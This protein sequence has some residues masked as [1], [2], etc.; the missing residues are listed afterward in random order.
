MNLLSMR[1]STR[2]QSMIGLMLLGLLVLCF[3]SL[4]QLRD[5]L[6]EDRKE[7][8]KNLVEVGAGVL[9]HFHQ[10]AQDGKL[11]ADA[12]KAAARESLRGLRYGNKDYYFIFDTH[13]VYVLLPTKPEFEGQ[14][15]REM[16]DAKGI[17]LIQELV[18]VAQ[19]GGGF[20]DY[21]FPRAGKQEAE[22][23]ISYAA[24]FAPWDWVI[25][26]GI[27]V[28]D[29][30]Q[31]FRREAMVLGGI[32]LV[33]IGLL[34]LIGW[35]IG[36]GILR[37][38]GG[39]PAAAA[40]IMQRVAAGDLTDDKAHPPADSLLGALAGMVATLRRLVT[41]INANASQ[42]VGNAEQIKRAAE[43]IAGAAEQQ[44]DATQSMAAAIE[45]LTVSSSH[46]S[47]SARDT[48]NDSRCAMSL[49]GEGSRRVTEATAAIE[50]VANTV[51]G[52]SVRIHALR[53]RANQ[54]STIA[55]VIKEIAGQTNLLALNAAIEAARAGEQG[56][57]FAV[58]ADEVRKLAE[59]TSVATTEI[60]QMIDDIQRD[61]GASVDAMND[62]L[63]KVEEGVRLAG[64]ASE[65][66]QGIEVGATRTLTR[67]AEVASATLEQS[68]AS[69]SI[70]QRVEQIS[71]MVDETTATIQATANTARELERIAHG[72]QD[73][74][75]RFRV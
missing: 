55:S 63:P 4:F 75:G 29:V 47:D 58:V 8:V 45:Q 37:Q 9:A 51:S 52:A 33:L 28:S 73:Q 21:W 54:I 67:I 2:I 24:L 41:E 74:I 6:L 12:A 22:P 13:H 59:R 44:S 62:V 68:S 31:I 7:K 43:Q 70:A 72:L 25:G 53:D 42:L 30:D 1:V 65:S 17:F 46:I 5:T 71:R 23:K 3:N 11:S 14:D 40:A 20:V 36:A 18:K 15:K 66:L 69:T 27:Y 16:K 10:L 35:H 34:S 56:R 26:T 19:S 64:K 61:T 32:G 48:E 39:E 38:L 49:A 50:M 57:G 60:E